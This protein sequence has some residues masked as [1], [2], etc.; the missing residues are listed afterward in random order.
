[1]FN[2]SL[3]ILNTIL[4]LSALIVPSVQQGMTD[5]TGLT[6]LT[7]TH[8]STGTS[9]GTTGTS[10]G[11]ST[12]VI[13]TTTAAPRPQPQPQPQGSCVRGINQCSEH[14]ECVMGICQ[15]YEDYSGALCDYHLKSKTK[16]GFLAFF[17]GGFGFDRFYLGYILLGMI[18]LILGCVTGAGLKIICCGG[19][20]STTTMKTTDSSGEEVEYIKKGGTGCCGCLIILWWIIDFLL[21]V[22]GG[23]DDHNG[24]PL[25]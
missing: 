11:T 12:N 15:C 21:I 4:L 25:A 14:G 18:K 7:T 20:S 1:M 13:V 9:T 16:A 3:S 6:G 2:I 24:Y 19:C 10:T 17:L 8:P 5:T 23:L 22:T